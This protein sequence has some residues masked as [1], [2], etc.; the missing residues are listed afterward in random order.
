MFIDTFLERSELPS[1]TSLEQR[2]RFCF[3]A[4]VVPGFWQ[5][6]NAEANFSLDLA[7]YYFAALYFIIFFPP[8]EVHNFFQNI[9]E[10]PILFST[11]CIMLNGQNLSNLIEKF[12]AT[13]GN[14][15]P[16]DFRIAISIKRD[17][18]QQFIQFQIEGTFSHLN[19]LT[20]K[21]M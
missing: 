20:S 5:R 13:H 16:A 1:N 11:I 12:V 17:M 18:I 3:D 21:C 4:V 6:I 7:F 2:L 19:V 8:D 15:L 10:Y 9:R 14:N